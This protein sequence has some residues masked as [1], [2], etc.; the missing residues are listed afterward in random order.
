MGTDK[1]QKAIREFM[2]KFPETFKL[3][4]FEGTYRI[5]E[6]NSYFTGPG[7]CG[8]QMMLYTQKKYSPE[9]FLRLYG[10]PH[11]SEEDLWVDFVKGTQEE[12]SRNIKR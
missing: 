1:E 9:E 11:R 10:R 5:S 12:I 3:R 6:R 2:A 7:E 8:G 4:N